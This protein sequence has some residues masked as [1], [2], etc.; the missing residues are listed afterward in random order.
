MET[1]SSSMSVCAYMWN[2]LA[3]AGSHEY[4]TR[5]STRA[6]TLLAGTQTPQKWFSLAKNAVLRSILLIILNF[7][8]VENEIG[9]FI[10]ILYLDEM[11]DPFSLERS[12][13]GQGI[14]HPI[15]EG[16]NVEVYGLVGTAGEDDV[17]IL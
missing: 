3:K 11:T 13:A 12:R 5:Q 7:Y 15:T 14:S 2:L 1:R 4:R 17:I 9:I 8:G 6:P 10:A 16:G